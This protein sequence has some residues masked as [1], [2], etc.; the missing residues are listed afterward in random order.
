VATARAGVQAPRPPGIHS[1]S[2][3]SH[4]RVMPTLQLRLYE[5]W[6]TLQYIGLRGYVD[7][8]TW[9]LFIPKYG[10]TYLH[11]G[12]GTRSIVGMRLVV[13]TLRHLC[14][15]THK[16]RIFVFACRL[17]DSSLIFLCFL[18][19]NSP[20]DNSIHTFHDSFFFMMQL[21]VSRLLF[22]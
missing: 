12:H 15:P 7:L 5:R 11:E 10:V 18:L 14:L 21:T 2:T 19:I 8:H 16:C 17:L 4:E 1:S 22:L 9:W 13:L 6:L 3:P 20:A